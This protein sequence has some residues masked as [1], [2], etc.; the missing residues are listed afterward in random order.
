MK[1]KNFAIVVLSHSTYVDLWPILFDSYKPILNK[2][3]EIDFV[4]TSDL[5][6]PPLEKYFIKN[7]VHFQYPESISWMSA[8]KYVLKNHIENTYQR[9]LFSFDDLIIYK[10][11]YKAFDLMLKDTS[12]NYCKLVRNANIFPYLATT[13][14]KKSVSNNIEYIGSLVFPVIDTTFFL[15]ILNE[16]PDDL[17]PWKYEI[18]CSSYFNKEQKI[19]LTNGNLILFKNLVIKTRINT[20]DR[21]ILKYKYNLNY[22]G[23]RISL[24][25]KN[26]IIYYLKKI[27]FNLAIIFL[28]NSFFSYIRKIKNFHTS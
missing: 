16:M 11:N 21:F 14:K 28:P 6:S 13:F 4:I 17:T 10:I 7:L 27:S 19:F 20:I 3:P 22:T 23:Q 26:L 5:E 8:L 1:K 24:N 25:I 9:V 12:F 15:N 2:Y 18:V